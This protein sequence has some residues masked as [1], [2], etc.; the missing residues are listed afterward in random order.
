[1]IIIQYMANS[2]ANRNRKIIKKNWWNSWNSMEKILKV[3]FHILV[4]YNNL[5]KLLM[6]K[7]ESKKKYPVKYVIED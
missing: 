7:N 2:I 3:N 4:A 6:K 5:Y 1:M